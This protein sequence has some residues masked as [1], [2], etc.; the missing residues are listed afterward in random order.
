MPSPIIPAQVCETVPV[1]NADL[2]TRLRKFFGLADLL[3]DFFSWF[4]N[5]DGSISTEVTT[6]L[7]TQL[8][9]PGVI[10]YAAGSDLGTGWLLADG[11][12][13]S[14]TTYANLFAVIGT[15]Y[16]AG[17]G[18][19]TFTLPDLRGRSLIAAGT[20]SQGGALTNRA[21]DTKYVGEES[22]TMTTSEL[23]PHTHT[24]TE[25][26]T[27]N[28]ERGDGANLVW[29]G[30]QDAQTESTGSGQPFNVVH[31]C[32]IAYGFIKT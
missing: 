32:L 20:G 21:I 17:D 8:L 14:R 28:E 10:V 16:G 31:P 30:S 22:H 11:S 7:A 23:V 15:R 2:C 4:L 5:S 26:T 9:P 27:R 3:C 18:S 1:A 6:E 29:R 13:V 19:T 25:P 12:Q 24:Y